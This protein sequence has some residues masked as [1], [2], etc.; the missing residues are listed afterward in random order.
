[1]LK[2]VFIKEFFTEKKEVKVVKIPIL[3]ECK[4][5]KEWANRS[6]EFQLDVRKD[7][8]IE[9]PLRDKKTP[10]TSAKSDATSSG[11]KTIKP[12]KK[13]LVKTIIR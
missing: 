5:L 6:S 2:E 3:N 8:D 7:Y 4:P 11:S 12:K 1:M 10:S 13:W 9:D